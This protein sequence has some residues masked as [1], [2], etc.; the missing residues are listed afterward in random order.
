[1]Y[2]V[3]D[4]KLKLE[5]GSISEGLI[6][7]ASGKGGVGKSTVT[8]NLALALSK[9]GKEVGIIDADIHGFSIPR[10]LGLKDQPRAYNE[11]EIIPPEEK[12]IKVMSMGSFV[13]E[14]NPVIWR[15]PLLLGALQQFMQDVHWGELDYLLLDLPPGTGDM[16]LNIMQ[17]LPHAEI[18]VVTTP[19]ITATNVAGRIGKLAEKMDTGLVGVI[20]NMSYYQ[21][22]D[23]GHKDYI[24]GQGGGKKLA[25]ELKTELLGELP[26]VP[27]VRVGGDEGKPII[28]TDPD[29]EITKK[30]FDIAEKISA[31]ENEFNPELKPIFLKGGPGG[32]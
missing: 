2:E 30:Y 12:G 27:E 18:L 7:V 20:E 1:M 3:Q 16:A 15:A 28:I 19:Q 6:A 11:N 9:L 22:S 21:C 5:H 14:E 10:L 32:K 29:S 17:K 31:R 8:V 24:F 4:G 13:E 25:E 26:L 23:C